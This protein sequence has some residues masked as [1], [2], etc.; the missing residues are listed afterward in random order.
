MHLLQPEIKKYGIS[1]RHLWT[2][3]IKF[4]AIPTM[5]HGTRKYNT[6]MEIVTW[7]NKYFQM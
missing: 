3:D 5:C 7:T 6:N 2:P 1:M 4:M